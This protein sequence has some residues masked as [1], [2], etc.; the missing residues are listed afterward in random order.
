MAPQTIFTTLTLLVPAAVQALCP[1]GYDYGGHVGWDNASDPWLY[2]PRF[3]LMPP[4]REN[5]SSGMNDIN[6]G[7]YFNGTYHVSYQDHLNCLDDINQ[8]N[9]T[10]SHL[11]SV[12]LVFWHHLT[13][14]ITDNEHYDSTDGPWDGPGFICHG[15]PMFVYNSHMQGNDFN[16]QTKTATIP[17]VLS[18][19]WLNGSWVR[20]ELNP[21]LTFQGPSTLAPPWLH[22][23]GHYV[24]FAVDTSGQCFM[25][26]SNTSDCL[27]WA[28]IGTFTPCYQDSPQI[29]TLPRSCPSCPP[30]PANPTITHVYSNTDNSDGVADTYYLGHL[31]ITPPTWT[32]ASPAQV[33][34]TGKQNQWTDGRGTWSQSFLD[35]SGQR[36]ITVGKRMYDMHI[37][38]MC[39]DAAFMV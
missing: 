6:G 19:P 12:D 11:A 32:S 29:Y 23:D 1:L 26:A 30:T 9:Q 27:S 8:A 18:D 31:D 25:Y 35:A 7:F 20:H 10:F 15:Q 39:L 5:R 13:P 38:L 24:T 36:R 14:L 3:H 17:P 16:K 28:Q 4:V 2:H 37:C 34:E 21:S 22:E 33:L